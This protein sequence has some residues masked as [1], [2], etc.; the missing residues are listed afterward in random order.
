MP[1]RHQ[2]LLRDYRKHIEDIRRCVDENHNLFQLIILDASSMFENH[3]EVYPKVVQILL[4]MFIYACY[5]RFLCGY[6][7]NSGG[8]FY[9]IYR[10]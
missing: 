3:D 9:A 1:T 10:H 2:I 5:I 7:C 4:D 8:L 6:G